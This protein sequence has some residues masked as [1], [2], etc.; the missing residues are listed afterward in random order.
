MEMGDECCRIIAV[1]RRELIAGGYKRL[2]VIGV[3]VGIGCRKKIITAYLWNICYV[4]KQKNVVH[5]KSQAPLADPISNCNIQCG[6]A[7]SST[8]KLLN[9]VVREFLC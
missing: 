1:R 3:W 4:S 5:K 6:V 2:M 7:A 9:A 8:T